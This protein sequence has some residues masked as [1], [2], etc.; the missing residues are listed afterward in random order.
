MTL[1]GMKEADLIAWFKDILVRAGGV[2]RD[3]DGWYREQQ[4]AS[5]IAEAE[6]ALAA[7]FPP[8]HAIRARWNG[9]LA[10][11]VA[12]KYVIPMAMAFEP[13]RGV[14]EAALRVLEGGKLQS[15]VDGIRAETAAGLLD[16]AA[17]LLPKYPVAAAVIAGGAL[18]THLLHLCV[19][20]GLVPPGD[21]S[22]SRYNDAIAQARNSGMVEVYSAT[23]GKQVTAWGGIRNDAAHIPTTFSRTA[24]E[25]RLM[26]DGVRQFIIRVP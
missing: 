18:E 1:S 21:G 12:Q 16:Q 9:V 10:N 25:V 3:G 14:L 26:I 19:R 2:S 17:V 15:L 23:E 4:A 13:A 20:N 5:W 11:V 6:S 7:V 8:S 22:I 24:D